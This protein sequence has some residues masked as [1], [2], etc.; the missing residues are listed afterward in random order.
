MS[1]FGR[2]RVRERILAEF[3]TRP[4]TR[5]HVREVARRVG[6]SPPAAA[7]EL[8]R[9]AADG[10][11]STE[12]VGRSLVYSVNERSPLVP[13]L[14]SLVQKT[15]GVE[16]QLREALESLPGLEAAYIFGSHAAGTESSS[17]DIDL[18][19]V[20]TPDR[21]TLS[22]RLAPLERTFRRDIN[23]VSKTP[24]ELQAVKTRGD[25]FWR[26]VLNG[27]VIQVAGERMM[28]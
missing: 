17:S 24:A 10:V 16:V 13:P 27:P 21:V 19:L 26:R 3:F 9:L 12:W 14:R 8:A 7:E 4:G 23:V 25:A 11:L 1:I 6:A 28:L 18:L 5:A 15:V 22:E 20:G 2:S